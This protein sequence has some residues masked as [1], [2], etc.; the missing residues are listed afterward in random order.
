MQTFPSLFKII[1]EGDKESSR[2]AARG[3]RKLLYSSKGGKEKYDEI[4]KVATNADEIYRDIQEEWRQENFVTAI[5]VMYFLHNREGEQDFLFPWLFYLLQ[6]NNG[7]IRQSAVRM[8]KN[9]L[10]PLTVHIR[11]PENSFSSNKIINKKRDQILCNMYEELMYLA[12]KF[13][14]PIYRKYKYI[15]SIPTGQY[16][17]IQLVLAELE[18]D[19]GEK[20][21]QKIRAITAN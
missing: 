9:E 21:I 15:A 19:C 13:Y 3:V 6:H 2:N 8:F 16:K 17:S 11:C 4:Q 1:L 7:N 20:Y 12:H 10:G 5:S 14:K 18:D